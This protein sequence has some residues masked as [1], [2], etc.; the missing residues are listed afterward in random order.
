MIG[1]FWSSFFEIG[2]HPVFYKRVRN[3]LILKEIGIHSFLKSAEVIG[4]K[5]DREARLAR[6]E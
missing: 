2:V 1:S 4:N 3:G 6:K 5:A